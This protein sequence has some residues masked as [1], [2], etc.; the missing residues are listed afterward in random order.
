MQRLRLQVE[1]RA[2]AF[3]AL[4][5]AERVPEVLR[6]WHRDVGRFAGRLHQI[7]AQLDRLGTD[8]GAWRPA[9]ESI[10]ERLTGRLD[11]WTRTRRAARTFVKTTAGDGSI[12]GTVTKALDGSPVQFGLI[13]VFS[14]NGATIDLIDVAADGTFVAS[15]LEAGTYFITAQAFAHRGQIYD[16]IE[17]TRFN[18][19]GP[20]GT[21]IDVPEGGEVTDID[22]RL[23]GLGILTGRMTDATTGDPLAS[24]GVEVR[25]SDGFYVDL[26]GTDSD[27][28]YRIILWPGTY[29]ATTS[30]FGYQDEQYDDIPCPG[31]V[32]R[33]CEPTEGTP[34]ELAFET[35]TSGVDFALGRLGAITGRVVD[36]VGSSPLIFGRLEAWDLETGEVHVGV[37]DNDG[38]YTIGGL[39]PGDYAVAARNF[40]VY[41]DE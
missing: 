36:T 28:V 16:G 25:D 13:E 12:R 39:S 30:A 3:G 35:T 6:A 37:T 27:G 8:E 18:C 2:D 20:N 14:S 17:C 41:V 40:G 19:Y 26:M 24:Q 9:V 1:E 7:Q 4:S 22:F 32:S 5:E 34:I 10:R 38:N 33:G 23:T 15:G 31:G 11:V 29:F 21:A